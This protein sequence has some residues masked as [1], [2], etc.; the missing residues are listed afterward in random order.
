MKTISKYTPAEELANAISHL[1]GAVAA[2]IATF[3]MIKYSVIHGTT[4]HIVASAIYGG[5]MFLLFSFSGMTHIL[6]PGKAKIIFS[7]LDEIGIFLMIAGTYTPFTLIAIHGT[8][9][10]IIFG[11]EWALALTG[12]GLKLFD[13]QGLEDRTKSIFVVLYLTMGW[14]F[15]IAPVKLYHAITPAGFRL[16]L[17]AGVMYS[18]GVIFFRWHRL[19]FHH[20]I[21]HLFVLAAAGLFFLCI[22]KYVL[23]IQI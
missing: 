13:K 19:K 17:L 9:G 7:Y 18:V 21:W 2:A 15:I 6:P 20:L 5:S 4:W 12:I 16:I 23:P 1:I 10:W 3:I 22:Y 11:L 14:L 8:T